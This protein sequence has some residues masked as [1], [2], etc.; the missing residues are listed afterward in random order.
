MCS[1]ARRSALAPFLPVIEAAVARRVRHLSIS[2]DQRAKK[3]PLPATA[4]NLHE[5]REHFADHCAMCHANSGRGDTAIG[6][7]LS[8]PTGS[9]D[10]RH[11]VALRRGAVRDH[12]E[13]HP[14]HRHA[15]LRRRRRRDDEQDQV[16]VQFI[17][18]LPKITDKELAEM[19]KMN[20]ARA[21]D[22]APALTKARGGQAAGP[23]HA[24]A[25]APRQRLT[26][27]LPSSPPPRKRGQVQF[28]IREKGTG[29]FL[30]RH[31]CC[32]RLRHASTSTHFTGRFCATRSQSRRSSRDPVSTRSTT[33]SSFCR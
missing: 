31:D 26:R 18:H 10:S 16:L 12:R 20:P 9:G 4:D 17:R 24:Q 3:S 14:V 28:S 19:E 25:P 32:V 27:E 6:G 11:A 8:E 2:A 15:R 22:D 5:G 30:A 7:D 33:S 13:R 29:P 1:A 21:P 23:A